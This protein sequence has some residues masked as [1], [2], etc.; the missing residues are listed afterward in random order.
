MD[1]SSRLLVPVVWILEKL[2]H[3]PYKHMNPKDYRILGTYDQMARIPRNILTYYYLLIGQETIEL[4]SDVYQVGYYV[5]PSDELNHNYLVLLELLDKLKNL[6]Y[7]QDNNF[8]FDKYP[9]LF[10]SSSTLD[11]IEKTRYDYASSHFGIEF[12]IDI[13]G[14][15]T[16]RLPDDLENLFRETHELLADFRHQKN[17]KTQSR[18]LVLV[19]ELPKT[20]H[21]DKTGREYILDGKHKIIF[22]VKNSKK[23]KL[24][25]MLINGDGD[26]V[27][28]K[29]IIRVLK[30]KTD[31]VRSMISQLRKDIK[32]Y[33]SDKIIWI[34]TNNNGSYKLTFKQ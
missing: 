33:Q 25:T 20:F 10:Q 11:D 17:I 14:G 31:D 28:K 6:K 30:V 15:I 23:L 3:N 32:S 1:L 12:N 22:T 24:F 29:D 34:D 18:T 4:L 13:H 7:D 8:C 27:N 5:K 2:N 19:S 26:W 9:D 16:T 21:W